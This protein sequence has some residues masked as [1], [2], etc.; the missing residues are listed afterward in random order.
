MR[1]FFGQRDLA[2]GIVIP[3]PQARE[4][5]ALSSGHPF[6]RTSFNLQTGN[7]SYRFLDATGLRDAEV[8]RLLVEDI[9]GVG[10]E[11]GG[12]EVTIKKGH[13]K[14]GR[15]RQVPVLPGHEEDV[16][17]LREGRESQERVFARVPS[18]I[19]AQGHRRHYAQAY[20]M[21]LSGRELPPMQGRLKR[22]DL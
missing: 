18:R 22:S 1:L 16:L 19:H 10:R 3:E 21:H 20:Y 9:L 6:A 11:T 12:A 4:H 13:G 17:R 5:H 2:A 15:P 8:K 7:R 14:G